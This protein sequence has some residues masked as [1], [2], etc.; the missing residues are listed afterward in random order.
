ME[1]F[2]TPEEAEGHSLG[3]R[4]F[5]VPGVANVFILPQFLTITKHPAE[6]WDVL[7]PKIEGA[8]EA[9]LE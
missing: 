2:D 7:I 1:S 8:I 9:A 6:D 3:R 5:A 4:I